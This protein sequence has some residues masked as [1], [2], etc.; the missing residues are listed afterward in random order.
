MGGDLRARGVPPADGGWD[1]PVLDPFDETNIAFRFPLVDGAIV[2]STTR[3]RHWTRGGR[4]FHHLLD[5]ATGDST[6][7]GVA[8]V[9]VAAGDAWWA[10]GIAKS[11]IVGGA[12]FGLGLVG[13]AHVRAWIY[14]DDGR[15]LE[16]GTT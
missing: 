7:T 14:F 5:P 16:A 6:R 4:E 9:V 15:V 2:T 13:A 8:A 3:V 1:V 11:I 10:E 12:D